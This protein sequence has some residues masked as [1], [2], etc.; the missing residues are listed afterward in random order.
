[1]NNIARKKR[2]KFVLIIIASIVILGVIFGTIDYIRAMNGKKPIFIYRTVNSTSIDV[3]KAIEFDDTAL[4][5]KEGAIYY[6][7]GYNV[8]ICDNE[9]GN[10]IFQLGHKQKEPCFTS[11]TCT[12]TDDLNIKRSF[13]YSFFDGNL[14]RIN[15]TYLIPI[16]NTDE[17]EEEYDN[18]V[19]KFNDV[20][21]CGATFQKKS[22]T[23][24][25][26]VE[27]CNIVNMSDGDI[28]EVYQTNHTSL[29]QTE[30]TRNEIIDY[31]D[32]WMV[33]E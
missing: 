22:E 10:Y 23:T 32:K 30:T 12:E 2:S 20:Y 8:S 13:V 18:W 17:T 27:I 24:Y 16:E 1:M 29:E 7:I 26:V 31:Y 14:Y 3:V 25:E 5:N 9:T 11:L 4:S 28:H 33:C 6:G 19:M 15:K 21:G